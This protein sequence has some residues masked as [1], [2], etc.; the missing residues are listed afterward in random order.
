[1]RRRIVWLVALVLVGGAGLWAAPETPVSLAVSG[2]ASANVSIA[3]DGD[4]VALAWSASLPS[5]VTDIYAAVSRDG[6]RTFSE[7]T[8]VNDV[9]GDARVSGEQPP[10]V[11]LLPRPPREP[12]LVIVWTSRGP[13]GTR[14]LQARSENGGRTFEASTLVPGGDAVGN[15]GW[16][17]VADRDG[18]ALAVWLDHRGLADDAGMMMH[19]HDRGSRPDGLAMAQ[20]SS[21]YFTALDGSIAPR[22]IDAG[23][24]YCCK[25]SVVVG[26]DGAIYAAWRQVYPGN[27]RDIAFTVSRDGGRSFADP[28]RVSEDRWVLE[29]CPDDGPAL[30]VDAGN[31]VH[32]V[33]P[34]LVS[35]SHPGGDPTIAI[36]Y[37]ST[38][39]GRT[40][41]ARQPLPTEGTPH[42]PQIAAAGDGALAV[43]WDELAG[44]ARRAVLAQGQG[45]RAR[46][47]CDSR[48]RR[49]AAASQRSIRSSR[50]SAAASSSRG[51]RT[52]ERKARRFGWRAGSQRALARS[53]MS[54]SQA[55]KPSPV[56]VDSSRIS[57]PG[58][59]SRMLWCAAAGVEAGRTGHVDLGDDRDV[60]RVEDRRVLER[61]VFAFGDRHQHHA[62]ILAEIVA[63][64]ADQVADVLDEQHVEIA[65]RPSVERALDHLGVEVAHRAGRDLRAPARR[66]APA[67]RRRARSRGRRRARR[68]GATAA[69]A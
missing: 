18:V 14:M 28:V 65:E 11:L 68:R 24:C 5:G 38:R 69:G 54:C 36:F 12:A 8:R 15:R 6:G 34:T 67:A 61:L 22:A 17:S 39:D 53:A 19:H 40:F 44:G 64:R 29:G 21:L 41:A 56:N 31:R 26:R 43:T 60:G 32:A 4:F 35:S 23:V 59:T 1:M 30:A 63:G 58:R 46:D 50:P 9:A 2:R 20:K 62:E 25:T 7:P 66:R 13:N 16:E 37:A 45:G 52:R 57:M 51:P 33:W 10:R 49:S 42:H 3:S 55:S 47:G 27:I 48:A